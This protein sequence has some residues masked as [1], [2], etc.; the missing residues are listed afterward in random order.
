MDGFVKQT[1]KDLE[2]SLVENYTAHCQA[3]SAHIGMFLTLWYSRRLALPRTRNLCCDDLVTAVIL[4]ES[5]EK[6]GQV[7]GLGLK[8]G[9][10]FAAIQ[11]K[12][13]N[14]GEFCSAYILQIKFACLEPYLQFISS[15]NYIS[16][17]Y[18]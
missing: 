14:S 7:R 2:R 9:E 4:F 13:E 1:A 3:R 15:R 6:F 11:R 16:S 18:L 10:Y 17:R 5:V 12:Q 8:F